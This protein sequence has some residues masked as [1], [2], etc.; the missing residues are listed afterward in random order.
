MVITPDLTGQGSPIPCRLEFPF[1]RPSKEN[2]YPFRQKRSNMIPLHP[3]LNRYKDK[4]ILGQPWEPLQRKFKR[5]EPSAHDVWN[6]DKVGLVTELFYTFQEPFVIKRFSL[7]MK[8]PCSV[9]D[10]VIEI[11]HIPTTRK[12]SNK[13]PPTGIFQCL[14]VSLRASY[15]GVRDHYCLTTVCLHSSSVTSRTAG[16]RF[17]VLTVKGGQVLIP[18]RLLMSI[19]TGSHTAFASSAILRRI[20]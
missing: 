16:W 2:P 18:R 20:R 17:P 3:V 7:L 10:G 15:G 14:K 9:I 11:S 1:R 6:Y 12:R 13:K 4:A 19:N 5:G 8:T